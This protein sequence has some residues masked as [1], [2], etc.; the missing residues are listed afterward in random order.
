MSNRSSRSASPNRYVGQRLGALRLADAGRAEE[1]ERRQRPVRV[2]EP[3]LG[4]AHDVGDRLDRF[5]LADDLRRAA[6]RRRRRGR[7]GRRSRNA[8]DSPLL[9]RGTRRSTVAGASIG[10]LAACLTAQLAGRKPARLAGERRVADVAPLQVDARPAARRG[11]TGSGAGPPAGAATSIRMRRV[12]GSAGSRTRQDVEQVGEAA[13]ALLQDAQRL[14]RRSRPSTRTSRRSTYGLSTCGDAQVERRADAGEEQAEQVVEVE[15]V[16]ALA[17]ACL[18]IASS[19]SSHWPTYDMPE[20][21]R[22]GDSSQ[23]LL[24][25]DVRLLAVGDAAVDALVQRRPS[26]RP[27]AGRRAAPAGGRAR[28]AGGAVRRPRASRS[29]A[30]SSSSG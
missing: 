12:C 10:P 30:R 29:T 24:L 2:V 20:I 18:R 15:D 16:V 23:T 27:A 13:V 26:C 11:R 14:G 1:Q 4:D 3:G 25:V 21:S 17:A 7:A 6:R 8:S 19:R 5:V 22:C 28:R 9:R